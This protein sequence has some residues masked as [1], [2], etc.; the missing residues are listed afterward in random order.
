MAPPSSLDFYA[1]HLKEAV[2]QQRA[3]GPPSLPPL[4]TEYADRSRRPPPIQLPSPPLPALPLPNRPSP[5]PNPYLRPHSQ[6]STNLSSSHS[7]LLDFQTGNNWDDNLLP[8]DARR[9]SDYDRR[10]STSRESWNSGASGGGSPGAIIDYYGLP[11]PTTNEFVQQAMPASPTPAARTQPQP[12]EGRRGPYLASASTSRPSF[13]PVHQS[14]PTIYAPSSTST[15]RNQYYSSTAS[16]F[17]SLNGRPSGLPSN[18]RP[19]QPP[20]PAVDVVSEGFYRP[21]PI[22]Y[23]SPAPI[24]GRFDEEYQTLAE[25]RLR[26]R[27]RPSTPATVDSPVPSPRPDLSQDRA[28][29]SPGALS[30]GRE[31]FDEYEESAASQFASSTITPATISPRR[32]SVD[33]AESTYVPSAQRSLSTSSQPTFASQKSYSSTSPFLASSTLSP[34]GSIRTVPVHRGDSGPSRQSSIGN[35]LP[36]FLNPA[37]LSNIAVFVKQYVKSGMNRKGAVEYSESFTGQ[38]LVVSLQL[39]SRLYFR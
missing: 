6:T 38:D 11:S 9:G 3:R 35:G 10:G 21:A 16:I 18:P 36:E 4:P 23:S 26:E 37:L 25:R 13:P 1:P 31:Q 12:Y 15:T 30:S 8:R 2:E 7:D 32:D 14:A 24:S 22:A 27:T 5:G 17:A 34:H 19:L 20:P 39:P 29:S 28:Y 33:T